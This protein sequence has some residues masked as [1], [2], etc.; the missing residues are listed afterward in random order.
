VAVATDGIIFAAWEDN[1]NSS[2]SDTDIY[3]SYSTDGGTTFLQPNLRVTGQDQA[4]AKQLS[5]ALAS[6]DFNNVY[7]VWEDHLFFYASLYLKKITRDNAGAVAIGTPVPV[8]PDSQSFPTNTT[9]VHPSIIVDAT[10]TVYV[11]WE[12]AVLQNTTPSSY[13]IYLAGSPDGAIFTSPVQ[14]NQTKATG[15]YGGWVYPALGADAQGVFLAWEDFR[16]G[17]LNKDIYFTRTSDGGGSFEP[18][19][20]INDDEG[21]WHEKPG[22]AVSGGKTVVVWTDFRN[23]ASLNCLVCSNDVFLARER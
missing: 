1:R 8:V 2:S 23:T 16:N 12:S 20:K 5:P 22:L 19:R 17:L 15:F 6:D 18:A 11:A 4:F 10:D 21:T 14:V 3:L 7:I 13:N 9:Q